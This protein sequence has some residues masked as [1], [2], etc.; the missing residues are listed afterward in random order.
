MEKLASKWN[1]RRTVKTSDNKQCKRT[2]SDIAQDLEKELVLEATEILNGSDAS[3][4]HWKLLKDC[5][6]W[7]Q[8]EYTATPSE[9]ENEAL[10]ALLS[11]TAAG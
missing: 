5:T 8:Q 4:H 3:Y 11:R 9:M 2:P 6:A 1:V 10:T 7:V